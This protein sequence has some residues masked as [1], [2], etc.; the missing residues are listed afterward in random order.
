M[1]GENSL[2]A[3]QT[4]ESEQKPKDLWTRVSERAL[5]EVDEAM[6]DKARLMMEN[7]AFK[8]QIRK[9]WNEQILNETTGKDPEKQE[10]LWARGLALILKEKLDN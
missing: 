6:R 4:I 2:R 7:P 1:I 9:R 5:V 3:G 10:E 8:Q